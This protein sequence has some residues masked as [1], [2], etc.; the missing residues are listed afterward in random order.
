MSTGT[1]WGG[2]SAESRWTRRPTAS[3]TRSCRTSARASGTDSEFPQRDPAKLLL[4]PYARRLT[5]TDYE[6]VAAASH[7]VDTLGRAPLG[8]VTDAVL[9]TSTR[10]WVPW[11][12]T[13][14]YEAHVVGLT[15]LHPDVPEELRGTFLGV[16][17]PAVIEHLQSLHVTTLELMPVHAA[18]AEPGLL[19][20]G[21]QNYWGYSTLGFFAPHPGYA[22]EPGRELEEFVQMVDQLHANGI[23]LVL[24]VV[25]NHTC[26]GGPGLVVD[27]CWR[28]LSPSSYYLPDGQDI[29]GTGNTLNAGTLPVIRM[30]TDSMRYWAGDLGV[31]GFRL[32]L[33]SVH[34]RPF[35]RPFDAGLCAAQRDRGRSRARPPAS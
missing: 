8:V 3:G 29:T 30:V 23:E 24:D 19:A 5:T 26:E 12:Q 32:D 33:A 6:L 4:D 31:D 21:R 10:P 20:K 27:L 35:G 17:H 13:V 28:G 11:E 1:G 34:G 15:R 22:T 18:A 14:I 2:A 25:Y 7:G 16:T 9:S